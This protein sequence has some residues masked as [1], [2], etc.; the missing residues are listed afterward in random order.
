MT[1]DHYSLVQQ[2]AK[3]DKQALAAFLAGT[4]GTSQAAGAGLGSWTGESG[5]A[6]SGKVDSGASVTPAETGYLS[7][8]VCVGAASITVYVD[9]VIRTA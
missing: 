2:V 7:G 9:P 6:W 4:A 5:T 8:R 3:G 1:E